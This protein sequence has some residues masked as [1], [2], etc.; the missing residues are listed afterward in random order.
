M[1][2]TQ[3]LKNGIPISAAPITPTAGLVMVGDGTSFVGS[4]TP[5]IDGTNI[6][7]VAASAPT[8]N[9]LWVDAVNGNDGTAISG[10]ADKPFLTVA[11]AIAAAVSGDQ[12]FIRPGVYNLAA[13]ITIPAGVTIT[14]AAA[15]RVTLQML[16]V[17]GA[18]TLVT[19][20]NTSV[21]QNV[22]LNLTTVSA[23]ALTGVLFSGTTSLDASLN[24]VGITIT[25]TV[26]AD[27]A[28]IAGILVQ[29]TGAP[30]R[31]MPNV[32]GGSVTVSSTGTGNNRCV[33]MNTSAGTFNTVGGG[34]KVSGSGS[35][36]AA[37]INIAGGTLSLQGGN[38]NGTT[39]DISQTAGTLS[40]ANTVLVNSN[41][42]GLGFNALT[43][44]SKFFWGTN[45][46]V[47]AGTRFFYP[48]TAGDSGN[49]QNTRIAKACVVSNITVRSRVAA[50][51]G[52]TVTL[53]KNGANT[54]VTVALPA[55]G[56]SAASNTTSVSFASG[57]DMALQYARGTAGA[58]DVE[59]SVEIYG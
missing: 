3:A 24:G 54:A 22:S 38:A 44:T 23:V 58:N 20:S 49:E 11:A 13:G 42:N 57:D 9:Q 33:L 2:V 48:G 25:K 4:T 12:I 19:M 53:R 59:V 37:E 8:G 29:S 56:T 18:T 41:A 34:F 16:A 39:A 43:S 17:V 21:V 15:S 27:A 5:T 7:N 1:T 52:D 6:F 30:T 40:V 55:A 10:Q 14:G 50:G 36:I 31:D 35:R 26:S 32:V 47:S 45:G 46:A 51:T 28:T